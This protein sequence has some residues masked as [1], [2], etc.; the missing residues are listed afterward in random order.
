MNQPYTRVSCP[1]DLGRKHMFFFNIRADTRLRP[2]R[3]CKPELPD[4]EWVARYQ[5]VKRN[6]DRF[7]IHVD[8]L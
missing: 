4:T 2:C 1:R 5:E 7:G 6:A 8:G 3:R